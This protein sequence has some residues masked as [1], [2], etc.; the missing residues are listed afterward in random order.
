MGGGRNSL[1]K[2]AGSD[3]LMF[4]KAQRLYHIFLFINLLTLAQYGS[5][6][7]VNGHMLPLLIRF[8]PDEQTSSFL[9]E[10]RSADYA[11]PRVRKRNTFPFRSYGWRDACWEGFRQ[12][13]AVIRAVYSSTCGCCGVFLPVETLGFSCTWP[14]GPKEQSGGFWVCKILKWPLQHPSKLNSGSSEITG[15]QRREFI[16]ETVRCLLSCWGMESRVYHWGAPPTLFYLFYFETKSGSLP[17][18]ASN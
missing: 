9:S 8:N 14:F 15:L 2:I 3:D 5:R 6:R 16:P 4:N 13:P 11:Q 17:R 10:E 1:I 7:C 18:L 12:V